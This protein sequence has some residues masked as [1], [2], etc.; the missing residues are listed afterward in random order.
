MAQ[1][2]VPT[3]F[4]MAQAKEKKR[5]KHSRT[6]TPGSTGLE[7]KHEHAEGE[8]MLHPPDTDTGAIWIEHG[9]PWIWISPGSQSTVL[10][11]HPT[12]LFRV[13][14][15][16]QT[17]K[18]IGI[19]VHVAMDGFD[20]WCIYKDV[21]LRKSTHVFVHTRNVPVRDNTTVIALTFTDGL[22]LVLPSDAHILPPTCDADGSTDVGGSTAADGST[23]V[24]GSTDAGGSTDPRRDAE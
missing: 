24:G 2:L 13:V 21:P 3:E 16:V 5:K 23:D 14:V 9:K 6:S 22:R 1:V 18:T 10:A 11:E 19:L 8:Y 4:S 15:P 12:G 20:Q 7:I 17:D